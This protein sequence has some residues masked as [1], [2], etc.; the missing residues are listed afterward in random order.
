LL[1]SL[2]EYWDGVRGGRRMPARA[3]IDPVEIPKVLPYIIMYNVAP[4]GGFTIRLVGE[5]VQQFVGRNTTGQPAGACMAPPAAAL[6]I[7]ILA[8]VATERAPKF[9]AGKAHWHKAKSY[10]DFEA[11]F[12]PLSSDG[13]TVDVILGG[14]RFPL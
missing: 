11:C 5:E 14:I 2:Y 7:E 8:A 10:R 1:R 4:G 12:L 13:E 9:R 6:M 3:D